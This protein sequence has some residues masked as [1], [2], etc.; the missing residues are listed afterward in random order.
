LDAAMILGAVHLIAPILVRHGYR[1]AAHCKPVAVRAEELPGEV[2]AFIVPRIAEVRNLGFEFLGI[3]DCGTLASN[4]QSYVASFCK[5]DTSDFAN[6]WVATSTQ[7]F[8]GY[9]EFS[10]QFSNGVTLETNS[11][12]AL[13]MTPDNAKI[14]MFRFL[15][16]KD[17][18]T[19]YQLHRQL[20]EKHAAGQWTP[21]EAKGQEME[22]VIS[23]IENYGPRHAKI[24]Y[25]VPA[26]D[27]ETYRLTWKG[28]FLMTWRGLWPTSL[29]RRALQR[30]VMRTE[31]Q[32]LPVHGVTV[33]RKA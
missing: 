14:Q 24:G 8:A 33:L 4:T 20:I 9:L 10:T 3:Y 16:I 5:R 28:A 7:K 1:F 11:N 31:L 26:K 17:A 15:R 18:R 30:K 25:M 22:R 19:L 27:G 6:V 23:V 32:T 29:L 2:R 13:P 12:R 21:G